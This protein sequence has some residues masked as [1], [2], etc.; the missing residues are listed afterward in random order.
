M[1]TRSVT[2]GLALG[3]L[4][5]SDQGGDTR[6]AS[7]VEPPRTA[8]LS[9]APA[10]SV[11]AY[12][13]GQGPAVCVDETHNNFHTSVGTYL[14]FA[15]VLGQDGYAV[16]RFTGVEGP[17]LEECDILV[18]A[19]AQPPERADDP[20]TFSAEEVSAL[21][22]WV[23]AGGSLF[24]I[25]DHMPDPGAIEALAASFGLEVH[26][27]Y[28]L[29]GSPDGPAR[30]TVFRRDDGSLTDDPLLDGRSPEEAVTQVATFLGSAFR[31]PD[32]FRPLLVL[33]PGFLSWAPE[34]YYE[35]EED[36]PRI[37]VGGWSQGGVLEHGRGRVAIFGEAA[38][39]TA[40]V[41]DEGRTLVGMNAPEALHN[42]RLLLNVMHWL[43]RLEDLP[44]G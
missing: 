14:P 21:D 33:G 34:R 15:D 13:E 25:T 26:D 29:E 43:G 35:F 11:P 39:F 20:P 38:M 36:S 2:I 16:H 32:G 37:D 18:I 23:A 19:D 40:Q 31:G 22:A 7:T 9:Y 41:F 4:A 5:C 44:D 17:K 28:V 1:T 10:L 42:L 3:L 6:T 12:P 8:D 30:P 27:G 24:L